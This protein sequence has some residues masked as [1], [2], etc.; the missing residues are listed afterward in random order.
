[1]NVRTRRSTAIIRAS[2]GASDSGWETCATG[3]EKLNVDPL[4]TVLSAETAP[5]CAVTMRRTIESVKITAIQAHGRPGA[6][7]IR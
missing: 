4:P 1:M 7:L 3:I 5:P 6:Q 2:C